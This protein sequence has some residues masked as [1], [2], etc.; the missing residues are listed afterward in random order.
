MYNLQTEPKFYIIELDLAIRPY[1]STLIAYQGNFEVSGFPREIFYFKRDSLVAQKSQPGDFLLCDYHPF[2]VGPDYKILNPIK[3]VTISE[4]FE[5]VGQT[6]DNYELKSNDLPL[7]IIKQ[8]FNPT[9]YLFE[10]IIRLKS[11]DYVNLKSSEFFDMCF[12]YLANQEKF[13]DLI[14]LKNKNYLDLNQLTQMTKIFI[15][16]AE[17]MEKIIGFH[18]STILTTAIEK[19]ENFKDY[20]NHMF[21]LFENFLDNALKTKNRSININALKDSPWSAYVSKFKQK[22]L[23]EINGLEI[24]K[25][26]GKYNIQA[27]RE[28][29]LGKKIIEGLGFRTRK[30]WFLEAEFKKILEFATKLKI[31]FKINE[32]EMKKAQKRKKRKKSRIKE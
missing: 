11:K 10:Q 25:K 14:I 17:K 8:V 20:L 19:S 30:K 24:M 4:I 26:A 13:Q 32:I 2:Y 27:I 5:L 6:P 23:N 12:E 9:Q 28:T 21:K 29:T 7:H 18:F 1:Y 31:N 22:E 3:A 16:Q 15:K